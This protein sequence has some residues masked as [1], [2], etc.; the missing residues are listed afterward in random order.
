M[1]NSEMTGQGTLEQT[2]Q[3]ASE[4]A[5]NPTP[6]P[7]ST[8]KQSP[9][10]DKAQSRP[11]I[12][13]TATQDSAA[14][15]H[16]HKPG[17]AASYTHRDLNQIIARVHEDIEHMR[18]KEINYQAQIDKLT[19]E[20]DETEQRYNHLCA[21]FTET[22]HINADEKIRRAAESLKET[23]GQIPQ[24]FEPIQESITSWLATQ[25]AEREA[26]LQ[27]KLERVEHQAAILRQELIADRK[28]LDA[29]RKKFAQERQTALDQMKARETW[30]QH[31]WVLKAWGTAAVM[32]LVLPAFQ[33][34]LLIQKADTLNIIII[35]TVSCLVLTALINLVRARKRPRPKAIAEKE[36]K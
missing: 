20:R 9:D 3:L 10:P 18:E 2:Q 36:K 4:N 22:M 29:E 25:Q 34:F 15:E 14:S 12:P 35:P 24:L 19:Q 16:H 23:P 32:F 1:S 28:A 5:Q 17:S 31:R 30:L 11:Y 27:Q 6:A 21:N 26:V 33:A 8:S 13:P 7:A